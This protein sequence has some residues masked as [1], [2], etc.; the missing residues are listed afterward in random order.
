V[1]NNLIPGTS[2]EGEFGPPQRL[3]DRMAFYQTPRASA[4]R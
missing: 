4:W 3:A 1:I 2:F